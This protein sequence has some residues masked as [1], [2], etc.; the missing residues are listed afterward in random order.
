LSSL[1]GQDTIPH[2]SEQDGQQ[3]ANCERK[4][5]RSKKISFTIH[6]TDIKEFNQHHEIRLHSA[7]DDF[8]RIKIGAVLTELW[9]FE[10]KR[11]HFMGYEVNTNGRGLLI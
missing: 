6:G 9:H 4:W 3:T 11:A 7:S 1:N 10:G 8:A 2:H 5:I